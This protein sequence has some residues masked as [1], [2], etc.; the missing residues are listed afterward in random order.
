[1]FSLEP[2]RQSDS[3]EYTQFTILNKKKIALNYP[4]SAAMGFCSKGLK[5]EF[6]TAVVRA[7]GVR[8]TEV[9]LH[10]MCCILTPSLADYGRP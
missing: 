7:I 9:L 3:N 2:P 8:A 1:M 6:E 4:K 5:N 10:C